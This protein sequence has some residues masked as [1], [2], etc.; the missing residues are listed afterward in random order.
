MSE[1][2]QD[3]VS[4]DWIII[5]PERERRPHALVQKHAK[6]RKSESKKYCPF[7]AHT[8]ESSGNWPPISLYPPNSGEGWKVA[9]VPNKYPALR[10]S[11]SCTIPFAHGPHH[12]KTGAGVHEL[13]ITKDHKKTMAEMGVPEVFEVLAVMQERYREMTKDG[14][15]VYTS[16]WFN[17]GPEAGATVY[18]PHYQ[19]LTMPII[20]P[21]VAHSLNGSKNYFEKH[22][23]CVHC[24]MLAFDLKEKKRVI[25]KNS[26][27]IA[28][29]PYVSRAPFE[30]RV[31]PL[32]HHP[33]FEATP[34]AELHGVAEI[35]HS[36]L[37]RVK[38]CLGDPDLNFFIHTAPLKDGKYD[39]YHWHIEIIPKIT[40][41]GGFELSTGVE[42]NVVD[43]E[44]AAAILRG[45]STL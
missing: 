43:P 39:Y 27:A 2:R 8:M 44:K 25:E 15:N 19:M 33:H 14:C 17:W 4:G 29:T 12:I 11:P 28:F 36:A 3:L 20:P 16:T 31:F 45:R 35:L 26:H 6:K 34:Q 32:K 37:R 18:H 41:L 21:D 10:H 30:I 5:A 22:G 13:V 24:V 40:I 9:V 1:L 38:S 23:R 42:I 7:E